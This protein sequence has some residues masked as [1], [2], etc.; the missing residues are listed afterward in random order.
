MDTGRESKQMDPTRRH[1]GFALNQGTAAFN[2]FFF[3]ILTSS[4][5]LVCVGLCVEQ[6][7]RTLPLVLFSRLGPHKP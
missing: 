4:S 3:R 7:A 2:A 6:K 5:S 1:F